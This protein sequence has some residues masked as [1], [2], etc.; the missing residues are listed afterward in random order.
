MNVVDNPKCIPRSTVNPLLSSFTTFE[1]AVHSQKKE[2]VV[3]LFIYA[4]L[5]MYL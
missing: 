3:S 5:I 1:D 2:D 4:S